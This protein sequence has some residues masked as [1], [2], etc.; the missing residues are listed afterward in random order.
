MF[1][2]QFREFRNG[3]MAFVRPISRREGFE[4]WHRRGR[5]VFGRVGEDTSGSLIAGESGR[6]VT[7]V[8][9]EGEGLG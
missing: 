1:G 4:R 2:K 6:C 3:D 7:W 8:W 5:L 9:D